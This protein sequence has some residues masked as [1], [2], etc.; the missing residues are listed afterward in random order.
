MFDESEQYD[1]L[2]KIVL[3]GW[4]LLHNRYLTHDPLP[5]PD[6]LYFPAVHFPLTKYRSAPRHSRPA[7]TYV[8]FQTIQQ[9]AT[10]AGL[11]GVLPSICCSTC[12]ELCADDG[13]GE[14]GY[15]PFVFIA[16]EHES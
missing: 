13:S 8:P 16:F 3:I 15:R 6:M 10:R 9:H 7:N 5:S 1:H 11:A 4:L 2:F 14:R 12:S